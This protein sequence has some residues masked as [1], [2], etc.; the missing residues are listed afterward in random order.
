MEKENLEQLEAEPD[1]SSENSDS[2]NFGKF[3]DAK[4]LLDAYQSLEAEFTRKSQK[5]ADFQKS[6]TES[7]VFSKND[8][9]EDILNGVTDSDQ[10]KKEITEILERDIEIS[11]LPNRNQVAFKI[12]KEAKR[13]TSEALNNPDFLDKYIN[14][15]QEIKDKIIAE[16]LSNLK[17]IPNA[18]KVISGNASNIYFSPSITAPK[19]LKEAGDILS[20]MLK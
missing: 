12:I 8:S 2:S 1:K 19:T 14:N 4:T 7:V 13:R 16:Y 15:K 11:N 5:L 10:Y 3:K 9:L 17:T 18:P 20:K 6:Q